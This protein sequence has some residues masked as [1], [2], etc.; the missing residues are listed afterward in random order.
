MKTYYNQKAVVKNINLRDAVIVVCLLFLLF[1]LLQLT[2]LLYCAA[3]VVV[4]VKNLHREQA[5][6][7]ALDRVLHTLIEDQSISG[8]SSRIS[9]VDGIFLPE[10]PTNQM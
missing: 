8:Y 7:P 5:P 4:T 1:L 6:G 2:L 3:I 10:Y 9:D